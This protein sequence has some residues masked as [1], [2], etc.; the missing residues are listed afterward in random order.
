VIPVYKR[1]PASRMSVPLADSCATLISD[2]ISRPAGQGLYICE[3]RA[4]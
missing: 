1:F 2:K 4:R 3:N